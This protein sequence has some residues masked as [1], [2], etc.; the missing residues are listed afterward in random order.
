MHVSNRGDFRLM[1]EINGVSCSGRL[2]MKE[3]TKDGWV[4]ESGNISRAKCKEEK[5]EE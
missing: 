2:T 1:N 3:S 4:D 5:D